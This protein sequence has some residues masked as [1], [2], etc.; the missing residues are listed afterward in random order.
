MARSTAC[1]RPAFPPAVADLDAELE[2]FA[3]LGVEKSSPLKNRYISRFADNGCSHCEF[4][5]S[6][7]DAQRDAMTGENKRLTRLSRMARRPLILWDRL[8]QR[9]Q[10]LAQAVSSSVISGSE[11]GAGSAQRNAGLVA[12][13]IAGRLATMAFG[14]P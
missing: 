10:R 5:S 13:A 8:A 2:R 4:Q 11:K 14:S 7:F 6:V 12:D 3:K 1:R 9:S